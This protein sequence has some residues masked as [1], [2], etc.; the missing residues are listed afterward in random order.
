M[1]LTDFVLITLISLPCGALGA[2]IWRIIA[3]R[4]LTRPTP[5]AAPMR[6]KTAPLEI[7]CPVCGKVTVLQMEIEGPFDGSPAPAAPMNIPPGES[8]SFEIGA[9]LETAPFPMPDKSMPLGQRLIKER[10]TL[11]TRLDALPADDTE[12][13]EAYQRR[14]AAVDERLRRFH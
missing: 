2:A 12:K 9:S 5:P 4:W 14:I 10:A 13:R 7:A 8:R 1:T 3:R 6:L 11:A